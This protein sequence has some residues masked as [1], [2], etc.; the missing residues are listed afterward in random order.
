MDHFPG[1]ESHQSSNDPSVLC[2]IRIPVTLTLSPVV[3]FSPFDLASR[4][5]A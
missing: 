2:E 4:S 1:E 3:I 5:N